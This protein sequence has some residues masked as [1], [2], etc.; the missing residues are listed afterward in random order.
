M[1]IKQ[2]KLKN[3]SPTRWKFLY[4]LMD[5]IVEQREAITVV[6]ASND[7][8]N[9][10]RNHE[11]KTADSYVKVLKPFED[12]TSM[13]SASRY[14]TLSMV[15]PVLNVLKH[16]MDESE[17]DDFEIMQKF[18]CDTHCMANSIQ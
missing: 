4:Y 8:V 10:L 17:M 11:W 3:E 18:I 13:M 14:P 6:L 15:I 12:V 5:R 16:L 1:N 2:H 7:K 9:N